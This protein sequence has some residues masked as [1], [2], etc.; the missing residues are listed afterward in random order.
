MK[1]K[2]QELPKYNTIK[3]GGYDHNSIWKSSVILSDG[4][5]YEGEECCKN[6]L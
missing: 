6:C 5:V 2:L 3:V 1:N 4:K